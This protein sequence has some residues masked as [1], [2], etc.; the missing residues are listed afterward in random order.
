MSRKTIARTVAVDYTHKKQIGATGEF[1]RVI[2]IVEPSEPGDG[3]DFTSQIVDGAIPFAYIP[4]IENGARAAIGRDEVDGVSVDIKV[5]L[6]AG[7]F[8]DLD[9]SAP[10][11]EVASSGALIEAFRLGGFVLMEPIM[12]IEVVT[13][14]D[15][16]DIVI[17][18]LR[19]RRGSIVDKLVFGDAVAVHATVP[20]V[21]TFGY[22]SELSTLSKG[23]TIC[24]MQVDHYEQV[25]TEDP[26]P[27]FRPAAAIRLASG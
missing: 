27:P 18:D 7:A 24:T 12:K 13:P 19:S 9:S 17:A 21:N 3:V 5:Q 11:F 22:E 26:D 15:Y 8:H 14:Q 20:L 10:A 25:P 6:I 23:A 2:L 16:T 1:A 4:A